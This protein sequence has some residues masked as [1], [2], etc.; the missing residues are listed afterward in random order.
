MN[1]EER[2]LYLGVLG[3]V[4]DLHDGRVAAA[5]GL[6]ASLA[7]DLA[8]IERAE[9]V[10]SRA[11]RRWRGG[12]ETELEGASELCGWEGAGPREYMSI[13]RLAMRIQ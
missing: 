3:D 11:E 7:E 8:E 6:A 5:R 13:G 4:L 9:H 12:E 1:D 10:E 2:V